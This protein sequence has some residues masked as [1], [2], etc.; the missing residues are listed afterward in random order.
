MI[1]AGEGAA[2]ARALAADQGAAMRAGVVE[3]VQ[4][5]LAVARV[6]QRPSADSARDE[7][8]RLLQLRRMAEI[9]PALAEHVLALERQDVV[10][11]EG[12]AMDLEA[13]VVA[14][15]DDEVGQF[16]GLLLSTGV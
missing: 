13:R 7:V 11:H 6:E 3:C 5:V 9:E 4:L 8:A 16:H 14:V 2:V 12:A 1:A 15:V 10:G